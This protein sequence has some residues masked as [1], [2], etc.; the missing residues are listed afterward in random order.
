M[1][2]VGGRYVVGETTVEVTALERVPAE[3]VPDADRHRLGDADPVWR[4]DFTRVD[5]VPKRVLSFEEIRARLDRLDR[6]STHG[7]WTWATL[8]LIAAQPGVVSTTLAGQVDRERFAFKADV[9]K[10][11]AL[12][13]TESLEVGY[14]LSPTGTALLREDGGS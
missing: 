12:G 1:V 13:L 14:R 4:V 3:T 6:A 10:L 7:P 5:P 8:R 11:K 9:R 2:K